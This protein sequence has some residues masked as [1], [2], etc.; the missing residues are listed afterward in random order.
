[1]LKQVTFCTEMEMVGRAE[2]PPPIFMQLSVQSHP[3]VQSHP[4]LR[5]E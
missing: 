3:V 1:M 4:G 2:P 5:Y